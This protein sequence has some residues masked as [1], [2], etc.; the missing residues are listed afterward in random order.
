MTLLKNKQTSITSYNQITNNTLQISIPHFE[1]TNLYFGYTK[2]SPKS[3]F[4][5]SQGR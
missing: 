3:D 1:F 5:P 2:L 4:L